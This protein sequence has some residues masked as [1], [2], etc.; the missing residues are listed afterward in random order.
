MKSANSIFKISFRLALTAVLVSVFSFQSFAQ[1]TGTYTINPA[2]GSFA[3]KN[4][5]S[6]GEAVDSLESQGVSGAVT[7]NVADGTYNERVT[8]SQAIDGASAVNTITFQSQSL[9]S[10]AVVITYGYVL[11]SCGIP[12]SLYRS[13]IDR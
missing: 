11:E 13:S 5:K 8:I 10:T 3:T 7:F 9:D 4:C 1:L 12:K 2:G 6:F